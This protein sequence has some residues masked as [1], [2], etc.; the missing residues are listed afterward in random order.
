MSVCLEVRTV[1][2]IKLTFIDCVNISS[3][4]NAS[5]SSEMM[6]ITKYVIC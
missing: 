5:I 6:C 1:L 2:Q 3:S 4:D